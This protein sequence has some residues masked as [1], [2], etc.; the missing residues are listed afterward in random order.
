MSR[1]HIVIA[2]SLVVLAFLFTAGL[3]QWRETRQSAPSVGEKA[4]V[5]PAAEPAPPPPVTEWPRWGRAINSAK[6]DGDGFFNAE[7]RAKL[8]QSYDLDIRRYVIELNSR[9]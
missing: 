9:A 5:P 7:Q 8:V 1:R 2:A 6:E 4:T 3:R